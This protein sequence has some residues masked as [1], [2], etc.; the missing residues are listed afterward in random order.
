MRQTPCRDPRRRDLNEEYRRHDVSGSDG[1]NLSSLQL[2]KEA[3]HNTYGSV[4]TIA[5]CCGF[6]V[7]YVAGTV[8]LVRLSIEERKAKMSIQPIHN[9]RP[10]ASGI[11]T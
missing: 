11:E 4:M 9:V 10:F 2:R 7:K 1:V 8:V 3:A 6:A 5:W